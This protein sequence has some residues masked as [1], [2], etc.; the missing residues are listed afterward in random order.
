M[1]KD[2]RM[3]FIKEVETSL[4]NMFDVPDVCKITNVIIKKLDNYDISERCTDIVLYDDENH[5]IIKRFSA[6]LLIEGKS[7]KTIYQYVRSIRKLVDTTG[8][9]LRNI[10]GY[11]I[12]LFLAF[13]KDRGLSNRSLENT[14]ANLSAFFQW[15]INDQIIDKNPISSIKPIK[16][17][18]SI[19]KPFSDIEIDIIKSSCSNLKERAIVEVLLSTGIRVSELVGLKIIDID[20]LNNTITVRHGKGDKDRIVYTNDVCIRH[21][22]KYIK[23]RSDNGEYVFYNKNKTPLNAG[24]VRYIL[25]CISKRTGINAVHPHR[26]RR[27][28]AT[29]LA[30]RGMDIQNI[31]KLLGHSNIDTT[32]TY[33]CVNNELIHDSYKKLIA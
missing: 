29:N 14:R 17:N 3:A 4:V 24:G 2:Y 9:L 20:Q 32:M 15:M 23:G 27:T 11:D 5:K 12:R 33:V 18:D 13:E 21:L 19:K 8:K 28:F 26:F 7:E 6:C 1:E 16:Y 31:Q 22:N 10:N 30:K 25:N